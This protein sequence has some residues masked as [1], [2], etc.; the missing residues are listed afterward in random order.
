MKITKDTVVT[1]QVKVAD[2]LGRLIE[3]GKEPVAYLHGDYGNTLPKIEEAL[4]GR[5]AGY[6]VTLDLKAADAFGQREDRLLATMPKREFPPGVKVG[7]Q[8]EGQHR[9][10]SRCRSTWS[11]SRAT[12][13]TWTPTTRWPARTCASCSRSP[14]CAPRRPRKSR[15]AT[16]TAP[17]APTT[18][19]A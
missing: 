5:E 16:R 4:E 12:P 7:G 9:T 14:A 3:A 17:T 6:A 2:S 19:P 10:A 13:C 15:T 11:R 8:L 1:M 18:R